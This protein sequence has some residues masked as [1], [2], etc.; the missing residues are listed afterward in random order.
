M[1]GKRKAEDELSTNPHTVKARTRI[2]TLEGAEREIEMAKRADT[3]AITYALRKL[4]DS[5]EYTNADN[6]T[7]DHLKQLTTDRIIHKRKVDQKHWS[8]V[9]YNLGYGEAGG[10]YAQ[11]D[12]NNPNWEDM[13]WEE[14]DDMEMERIW[15]ED[16]IQNGEKLP[17]GQNVTKESGHA[18]MVKTYQRLR[19]IEFSVWKKTWRSAR[20]SLFRKLSK[21]EK[22][23]WEFLMCEGPYIDR[24]TNTY[25]EVIPPHVFF[26]AQERAVWSN[27]TAWILPGN[28]EWIDLPGPARWYEIYKDKEEPFVVLANDNGHFEAI[29]MLQEIEEPPR[30]KLVFPSHDELR[31]MQDSPE[32]AFI[33]RSFELF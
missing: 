2:A 10:Q 6:T 22:G 16:D 5:Q 11:Y 23:G 31:V 15:R 28:Q 20:I 29:C 26:T 8:V 32:A 3:A 1:V 12:D 19:D 9:A 21:L 18:T 7:K 13:A 33:A 24:I 27:Y 30:Y 17:E 25:Y 14:V 4:R